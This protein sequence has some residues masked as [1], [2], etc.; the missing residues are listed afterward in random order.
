MKLIAV[1]LLFSTALAGAKE[2]IVSLNYIQTVRI[3]NS[4]VKITVDSEARMTLMTHSKGKDKVTRQIQ[5]PLAKFQKL[6]RNLDQIDWEKVS[7]DKT[8]GLDGTSVRISYGKQT[9]SLWS[10]EHDSKTRGLSRIQM[11]IESILDL[12]GLDRAGMPK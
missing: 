3:P 9:V 6:K 8:K 4:H 5:V 1:L 2:P 11:A 10:P 7:A 12:S